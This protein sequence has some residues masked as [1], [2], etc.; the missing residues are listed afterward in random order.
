M[1]LHQRPI[2]FI[3]VETTGLDPNRHEVID[4]AVVF[5]GNLVRQIEAPWVLHLRQ[6]E[7]DIAV[8]HTRIRPERIEDA[9]PKALEVNGYNEFQWAKAPTAAAVAPIIETLLTRA[10]ADPIICGHNVTFD[11]DFLNALLRRAGLGGRK[12][13]YHTVDTVTLCYE[14][15]VPCGLESV[16]LDNVRG[17]LGIPTMGAHA[18][19]KDAIDAR[20]VYRRLA[21]ATFWDRVFWRLQRNRQR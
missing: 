6:E 7:P 20:T 15:L 4:V 2:A 14:H 12:L 5:D 8:W 11:R 13:S 10:G 9:E 18:A 1:K 19:L 21:R 3:D 17:F 16:S